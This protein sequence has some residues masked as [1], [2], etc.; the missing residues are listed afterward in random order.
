MYLNEVLLLYWQ[1]LGLLHISKSSG[2][3]IQLSFHLFCLV[4]YDCV[5][6]PLYFS[7][8]FALISTMLCDERKVS[9]VD[10]EHCC[11]LWLSNL[12]IFGLS[13]YSWLKLCLSY[14]CS[15]IYLCLGYK[16][17][18]ISISPLC[19][20]SVHLEASLNYLLQTFRVAV[21]IK[22]SN[23]IYN[24]Q[25]GLCNIPCGYCEFTYNSDIKLGPV[26]ASVK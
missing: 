5:V 4:I 6:G 3:I 9:C 20:P 23:N 14:L 7:V 24:M 21:W 12:L 13:L 26:F 22:W 2:I 16:L 15:D 10:W 1:N 8:L 19:R 18:L 17:S 25:Y 11:N